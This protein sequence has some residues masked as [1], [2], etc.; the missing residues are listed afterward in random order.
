[1]GIKI[2][3]DKERELKLTMGSI[4][5]YKEKTGKDLLKGETDKE[6]LAPLVWACLAHEDPKLTVEQ[7]EDM[8]DFNNVE[9][10]MDSMVKLVETATNKEADKGQET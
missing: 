2:T 3:L 7:V 4:R 5:R 10:I 8:L 1:M 9:T 6:N